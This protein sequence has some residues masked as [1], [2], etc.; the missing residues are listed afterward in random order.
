MES[1]PN[2]RV[3]RDEEVKSGEK[4]VCKLKR[5][6]REEVASSKMRD[7][8]K[9][10]PLR[11]FGFSLSMEL[12]RSIVNFVLVVLDWSTRSCCGRSAP[13]S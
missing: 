10:K 2:M 11:S 6:D 12:R 3:D 5:V 7:W 4:V 8:L 1:R 9:M 13:L